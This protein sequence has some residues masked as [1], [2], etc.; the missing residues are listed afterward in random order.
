MDAI[1]TKAGLQSHRLSASANNLFL[2]LEYWDQNGVVGGKKSNYQRYSTRI[3]SKKEINDY[4]TVGEN[5]YLNRVENQNIGANNSF[6]TVISDAFAYDPV[7]NL[8]DEFA[9]YGYAQSKW[10]QKEYINPLSRLFI[11]SG[12]VSFR[13]WDGLFLV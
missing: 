2:S 6:G 7:T 13:F 1:F 9:Q 11:T 3:N 10:V 5:I 4:V 8:F 12:R